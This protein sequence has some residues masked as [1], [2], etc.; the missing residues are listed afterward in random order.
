M[1]C[2]IK[3]LLLLATKNCTSHAHETTNMKQTH[4][5]LIV[6]GSI[7]NH[8]GCKKTQRR[9]VGYSGKEEEQELG[10]CH[11]EKGRKRSNEDEAML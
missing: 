4:N 11:M 5:V 8:A 9:K 7:H 1:K 6:L 2:D 10:V 3:T